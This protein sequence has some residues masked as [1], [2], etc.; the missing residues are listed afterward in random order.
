MVF[1]DVLSSMLAVTNNILNAY[2][3]IVT[4]HSLSDL[5]LITILWDSC[6]YYSLFIDEVMETGEIK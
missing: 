1:F 5:I 3:V 2:Y 6:F 4:L